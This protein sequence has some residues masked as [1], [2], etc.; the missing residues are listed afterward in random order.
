MAVAIVRVRIGSR[1]MNHLTHLHGHHFA[2][3]GTDGR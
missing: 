2:V 3:S 1:I